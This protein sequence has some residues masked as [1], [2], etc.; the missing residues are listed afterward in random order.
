MSIDILIEVA[1]EELIK[2]TIE[3]PSKGEIWYDKNGKIICHICGKSFL[4]N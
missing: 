3:L 4:I 2:N 1:R